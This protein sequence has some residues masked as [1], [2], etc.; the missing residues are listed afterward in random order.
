MCIRT[1]CVYVSSTKNEIYKLYNKLKKKKEKDCPNIYDNGYKY[2]KIYN[3]Q[4]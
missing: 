3:M 4:L 1:R 2:L